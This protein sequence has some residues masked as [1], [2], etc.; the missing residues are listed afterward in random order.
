MKTRRNTTA[1]LIGL[2]GC[3]LCVIDYWVV[4]LPG[5][6]VMVGIASLMFAAGWFTGQLIGELS[7]RDD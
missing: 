3:A 1:S 6:L 4:E 2:L 5:V 7:R